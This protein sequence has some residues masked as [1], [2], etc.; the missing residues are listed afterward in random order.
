MLFE[1]QIS[2]LVMF[3]CYLILPK[4][5]SILGSVVCFKKDRMFYVDRKL[6]LQGFSDGYL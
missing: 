2:D 4:A 3:I 1:I 5:K 6:N